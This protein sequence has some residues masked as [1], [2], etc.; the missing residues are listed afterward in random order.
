VLTPEAE[1]KFWNG[2]RFVLPRL[3]DFAPDRSL[4]T[5]KICLAAAAAEARDEL[6]NKASW[7]AC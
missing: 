5:M 3:D 4:G 7:W 2:A 1:Q 6:A